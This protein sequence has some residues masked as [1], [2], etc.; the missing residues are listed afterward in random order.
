MPEK[1]FY[2]VNR[3]MAVFALFFLAAVLFAMQERFSLLLCG[4]I[5]ALLLACLQDWKCQ[6]FSKGWL[7][8]LCVCVLVLS[9]MPAFSVSFLERSLALSFCAFLSLFVKKEML[10]SADVCFLAACGFCFGFEIF[11][12]GLILSCFGALLYGFLSKEKCLPFIS[13]LSLG[14]VQSILLVWC[15]RL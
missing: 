12:F 7:V 3:Q 5:F 6:Y 15:G 8:L 4:V 11:S 13:F 2:P 9:G 10:G 14:F 1:L